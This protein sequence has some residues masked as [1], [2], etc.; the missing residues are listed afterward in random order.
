MAHDTG[1]VTEVGVGNIQFYIPST[2]SSDPECLFDPDDEFLVQTVAD[3]GLLL[4]IPDADPTV[5][6]ILDGLGVEID[7]SH[8]H[9]DHPV[10]DE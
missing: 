2:V 7:E 9:Y 3:V 6:D 4:T 1:T 8:A 5:A 10:L